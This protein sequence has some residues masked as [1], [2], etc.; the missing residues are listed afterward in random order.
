MKRVVSMIEI[1]EPG[2]LQT[3]P[4][5]SQ[6]KAEEYSEAGVPVIMP[7]DIIAGRVCTETLAHIPYDKAMVLKKHMLKTGDVLFSRR[8]DL[9]K[10]AVITDNETGYLC[11]TGCLRARIKEGVDPSYLAYHLGSNSIIAW[12]EQNAVG[13]TMLNLNTEIIGQLPIRLPSYAEQRKIA[14]T[15][16]VWDKAIDHTERLIA[17]KLER[18]RWLMQQLLTDKRRLTGFT[19]P[20]RDAHLGDIFTNRIETNRTDLSLVAITGENGVV[21]RDALDRRDTSSEDKSAYLRICP[22]DIGYN[23]MRMWQGVC[24]L[25]QIE[26]IVSPAYTIATPRDDVEG[27]FMALLFKSSPVI[28]LFHRHSQGLVKDT[29]NLKWRHFAEIK[30]K[31]PGKTEQKAI[32]AIF[33]LVDLELNL[34]RSQLDALREQKKGLMQQLLTGK[35]RVRV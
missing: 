31:I 28:H 26:G 8:G 13:Q 34:L 6:L 33:R 11:G 23:T 19:D 4:F 15:L 18:R 12:L 2:G 1:C 16:A 30:V 24:G 21:S 7:K 35:V 32:T 9:A 10:I 14:G 25:S 27:E 29:L 3:G 20:W 5:G 17:A 22:G